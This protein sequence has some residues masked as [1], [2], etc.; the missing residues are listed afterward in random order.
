ML[1]LLAFLSSE[2]SESGI[3]NTED[4][5]PI[6]DNR[7]L[8][9]K[10]IFNNI[11]RVYSSPSIL[12]TV[13]IETL[14]KQG[15]N[16]SYLEGLRD[17]SLGSLS[18]RDYKETMKEFPRRKWLEWQRSYW[19]SPPE[20]E[21]FFDLSDRI[22]RVLLSNILPIGLTETVLIIAAPNVLRVIIGYLN[23]IEEAQIPHIPIEKGIPYVI[24]GEISSIA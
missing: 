23:N 20:G 4:H 9:S 12:C 13:M 24:N 5:L 21:S 14:I 6:E 11:D 7:Y 2:P 15:N 22:K 18:G 10:N 16:V 3:W 1:I 17:R 19:V 8:L